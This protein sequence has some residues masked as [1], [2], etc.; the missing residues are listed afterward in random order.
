MVIAYDMAWLSRIVISR[1]LQVD[2]VTLV[3][4]VSDTRVVPEYIGNACIADDIAEGVLDVMANP[5]AQ[6]AAMQ[7]TMKRLGKGGAA[8]GHRA[9]AAVLSGL[10]V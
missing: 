2:T 1:M 10:A 3:N 9:A 8:P 4:L 6:L 5:T 7:V